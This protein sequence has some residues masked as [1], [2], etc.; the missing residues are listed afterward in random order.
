MKQDRQT[1]NG[2]EMSDI[3]NKEKEKEKKR[4]GSTF[5]AFYQTPK[6]VL[7]FPSS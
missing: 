2:A 3:K 1:D 6:T 4:K 5:S 7:S